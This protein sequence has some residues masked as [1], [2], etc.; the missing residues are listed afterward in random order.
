MAMC[1]PKNFHQINLLNLQIFNAKQSEEQTTLL[2]VIPESGY[3][4][5]MFAVKKYAGG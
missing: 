4:L 5:S 1:V 3:F 2:D